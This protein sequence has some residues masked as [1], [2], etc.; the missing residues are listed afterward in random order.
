MLEY[1]QKK[2]QRQTDTGDVWKSS[3]RGLV[4]KMRG[5]VSMLKQRQM[6]I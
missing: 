6:D 1:T 2:K 5:S 4:E 3:L